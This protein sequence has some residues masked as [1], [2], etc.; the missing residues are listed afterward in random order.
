[1]R[2]YLSFSP[3]QIALK[4]ATFAEQAWAGG[5]QTLLSTDLSA[6][7]PGEADLRRSLQAPERL[8]CPCGACGEA[9]I[10]DAAA[11]IPMAPPLLLLL[12]RRRDY[13]CSLYRIRRRRLCRAQRTV[14]EASR[15]IWD[16]SLILTRRR[17][18]RAWGAETRG[19]KLPAKVCSVRR[20][21]GGRRRPSSRDFFLFWF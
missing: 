4:G 8:R 16:C 15:S 1:M 7:T 19:A 14:P 17:T 6:A 12:R 10:A 18:R 3:T 11:S 2:V 20:G 5:K 13:S 21:G 9:R